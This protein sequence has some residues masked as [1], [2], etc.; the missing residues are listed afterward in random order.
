MGCAELH[1]V[2]CQHGALLAHE[3]RLEVQ[4]G[5]NAWLQDLR[6]V[7]GAEPR[8]CTTAKGKSGRSSIAT[9][10]GVAGMGGRC[11]LSRCIKV[12]ALQL[13]R[14]NPW[15]QALCRQPQ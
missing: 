12:R 6:Q 9:W 3:A 2:A 5:C 1:R 15:P 11:P 7:P 10:P 14:P 4:E 13:L 8:I